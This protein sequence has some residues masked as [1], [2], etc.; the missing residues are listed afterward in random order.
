MWTAEPTIG[1]FVRALSALIDRAICCLEV[2]ISSWL[3]EH[4]YTWYRMSAPCLKQSQAQ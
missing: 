3:L 1:A 2:S 4:V